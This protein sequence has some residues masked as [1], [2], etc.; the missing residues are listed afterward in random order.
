MK[1]SGFTLIELILVFAII[2]IIGA[3]SS[4]LAS[5]LLTRV[6]ADSTLSL[7]RSSLH[8]AQAYALEGKR[9]G[10]WGVCQTSGVIRLYEGT[11]ASPTYQVDTTIPA[12]VTISGLSDTSFSRLTG[13]PNTTS[14]ITITTPITSNTLTIG[15]LGVVD[16]N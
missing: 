15:T 2:V 14:T 6:Y 1:K 16:V 5:S 11:C 7:L 12:I 8:T 4:P 9:T 13:E 10:T 3:L